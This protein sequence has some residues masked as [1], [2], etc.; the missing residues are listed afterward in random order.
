[1]SR[2]TEQVGGQLQ[3]EIAELLQRHLRDPALSE[4]MVSI[5][6]VDVAGDFGSARVHVSVFGSAEQ[7]A[8]ALAALGRSEPVMHRELVKRL[9]LRKVPRLRFVVDHSIAEG[10][11]LSAIMRGLHEADAASGT[12]HEPDESDESDDIED[13]EGVEAAED[14]EDTEQ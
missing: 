11:R 6:R 3:S 13:T 5:V 8:A 2:R 12:A 14:A 9:H 1:M 10:D 4:A 7:E